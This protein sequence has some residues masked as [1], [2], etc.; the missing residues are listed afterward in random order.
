MKRIVGKIGVAQG[1]T[2]LFSDFVDDGVMWSGN[3]PREVRRDQRFAEPFAEAPAVMVGISMWDMDHNA[4]SRA[5]ISAESITKEGFQI[6]F[7][8]WSD[9]RV[10]RIRADWMAIGAVRDEDD[11]DVV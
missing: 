4:N 9:T 6:V 1:S 2:V 7:R 3:G 8:T 11:W 5:D 10:A